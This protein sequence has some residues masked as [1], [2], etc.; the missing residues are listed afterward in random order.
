VSELVR[1]SSHV[2][3]VDYDSYV[4]VQHTVRGSTARVPRGTYEE[5]LRF[6]GF[7]EP[8]AHLVPWVEA[9]VL[10]RPFEDTLE[11]HG[12]S[13]PGTE[14]HLARAYQSWYWHHEVE[15][16][17]EYRWLG[18][19]IVKM[20]SD[21]FFYQELLVGRG[22]QQVLEIGYGS[23]GGLW[24]FASMLALREGGLIVGVDREP[25]GS[26][27][28]F[29]R[30]GLVR[31]E[32]VQGCAHESTTLEGVRTLAP[33]G[34]GLVVLDADPRPEGKLALLERW[35]ALVRPR[36]YIVME[37]MESPECREATEP[38]SHGVDHFL[39]RHRDFGV[40]VEATRHPLLKARGAV[41]Q[42]AI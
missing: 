26:L 33:E 14:G 22:L 1:L 19:S 15:A 9:G 38:V 3:F 35:S 30:F 7:A 18:Y 6:Q 20:P 34:F 2:L 28:P 27:P 29:G 42:R 12:G 4:E 8:A 17:R 32:L 5:L 39:L 21:L 36:G 25:C 40:A 23:G 41:L 37:D 11:A 24:F 31:V 16:E 10:V 13:R